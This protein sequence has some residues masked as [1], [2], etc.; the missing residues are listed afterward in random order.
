MPEQHPHPIHT[1]VTQGSRGGTYI[2]S[3]DGRVRTVVYEAERSVALD[4]EACDEEWGPVLLLIQHTYVSRGDGEGEG[5]RDVYEGWRGMAKRGRTSMNG[6]EEI[7][8]SKNT[9]LIFQATQ[10]SGAGI[11]IGDTRG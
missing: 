8:G 4:T 1:L 9:K 2:V 7:E 6:L 10:E 3:L 11:D 5:C